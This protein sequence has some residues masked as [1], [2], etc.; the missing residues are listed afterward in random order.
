MKMAT[1][2]PPPQTLS[3]WSVLKDTL[4]SDLAVLC[5][6]ALGCHETLSLKPMG[7]DVSL[8]M[9]ICAHCTDPF[10]MGSVP[11]RSTD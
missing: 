9:D 2:S 4:S 6:P 11:F 1:W 5:I 3:P 8:S 10:V 7:Q